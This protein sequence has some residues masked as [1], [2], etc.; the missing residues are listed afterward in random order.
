MS[1]NQYDFVI[2]GGGTAGLVLAARLSEDA[3]QQVLVLEAG[4]DTSDDEKVK[5]GV[6]W[7]ALQGSDID[8]SFKTEPQVG[9]PLGNLNY[10][11]DSHIKLAE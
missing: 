10:Q 7:L 4:S 1:S 3:S 2:I 6:S 5:L 9:I 8:W 11:P